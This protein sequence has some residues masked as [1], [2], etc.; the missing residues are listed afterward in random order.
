MEI[1]GRGKLKVLVTQLYPTLYDPMGYSPPD[2]SVHGIFQARVLERVAILFSRGSSQPRDRTR[3][4]CIAGKVGSQKHSVH[5]R[6]G[7]AVHVE[8]THATAT[9]PE[10][11]LLEDGL[12]PPPG[13]SGCGTRA[14]YE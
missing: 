11:F 5:S 3:V 2:P 14:L 7:P 8:T 12:P 1:K 9:C 6:R 10:D 13:V 4:S